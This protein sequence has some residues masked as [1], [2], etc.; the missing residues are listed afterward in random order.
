M[1]FQIPKKKFKF[2]YIIKYTRSLHLLHASSSTDYSNPAVRALWIPSNEIFQISKKITHFQIFPAPHLLNIIIDSK[3][4]LVKTLRTSIVCCNVTKKKKKLLNEFEE[5][6]WYPKCLSRTTLEDRSWRWQI[7]SGIPR[8]NEDS[9]N[10][11]LGQVAVA[12]TWSAKIPF[13]GVGF[14]A[15]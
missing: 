9:H 4:H 12:N 14:R 13:T 11:D 10:H 6:G 15:F 1:I 2:E 8:R 3:L 7:L 5:H